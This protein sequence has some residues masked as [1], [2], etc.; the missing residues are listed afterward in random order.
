MLRQVG[1][2]S[3]TPLQEQRAQV[4]ETKTGVKQPLFFVSPI[5]VIRDRY[6]SGLGS[7]DVFAY[8]HDSRRLHTSNCGRFRECERLF[9]ARARAQ[10]KLLDR[11]A[12]VLPMFFID[13]HEQQ[14]SRHASVEGIYMSFANAPTAEH[15]TAKS[16]VL[17]CQ[18]P[19]GCDVFEAVQIVI[20]Q[21]MRLLERGVD[22]EFAGSGTTRCYGSTYAVLGDHPSQA[23]L[24][25]L[26]GCGWAACRFCHKPAMFF[27]Y[28]KWPCMRKD[29]G[30]EIRKPGKRNPDS[31]HDRHT[32]AIRKATS[33]R[34][35]TVGEGKDDL[36]YN[37]WSTK[38]PSPFWDLLW[39]RQSF[40]LCFGICLLH[41]ELLGNVK[42]HLRYMCVKNDI[43]AEL[44]QRIK[45]YSLFPSK[46]S[47]ATL[48]SFAKG[49]LLT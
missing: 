39:M 29:T 17:L 10:G 27:R 33:G 24:A 13:A 43:S 31:Y 32:E 42:R 19:T 46:S 2:I 21:Q 22:V 18:V 30:E 48:F 12:M 14:R 26:A 35:G 9:K 36:K 4:T 34:L 8:Q 6:T 25:G 38:A 5:D 49:R 7:S 28:T 45:R 37:G 15:R 11:C 20:V 1:R 40:F 23:K 16:R 41:L 3:Y 47:F 44:N